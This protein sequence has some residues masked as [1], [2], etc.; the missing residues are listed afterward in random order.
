MSQA[1]KV[2]LT[3]KT[4]VLPNPAYPN[5]KP[6]FRLQLTEQID[7]ETVDTALGT[8]NAPKFGRVF[9]V[10]VLDTPL[11]EQSPAFSL[12]LNQFKVV[13]DTFVNELGETRTAIKLYPLG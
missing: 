8:M 12:Y 2:R 10:K 4:Q 13:E 1:V 11:T 9:N 6:G 3:K 5:M 7:G